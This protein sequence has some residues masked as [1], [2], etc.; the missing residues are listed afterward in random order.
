MFVLALPHNKSFHH[1]T[2]HEN[3]KEVVDC[4]SMICVVAS[5]F[6]ILNGRVR[7]DHFLFSTFCRKE[8][9]STNVHTRA[10]LL[11]PSEEDNEQWEWNKWERKKRLQH[12]RDSILLTRKRQIHANQSKNYKIKL[13][14]KWAESV[15]KDTFLKYWTSFS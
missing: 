3:G 13:N 5:P 15:T 8:E 7:T 9:F 1:P 14:L 2:S 12:D 11:A 6:F 4:Y 10:K